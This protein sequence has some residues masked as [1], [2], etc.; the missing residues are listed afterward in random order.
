M[1]KSNTF[2][3]IHEASIAL[4][5]KPDEHKQKSKPLNS[6]WNKYIHINSHKSCTVECSFL[7]GTP[8]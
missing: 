2:K 5:P 6:F 7:N 8:I 1:K 4:I 3:L